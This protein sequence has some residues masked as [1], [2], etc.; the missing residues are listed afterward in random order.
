MIENS[1]GRVVEFGAYRASGVTENAA[2]ES[3]GDAVCSRA[4][5]LL[6]QLRASD[7]AAWSSVVQQHRQRLQALGRSYRLAPS[8][9]DDALQATW[10]SLL[11]HADELRNPDCL[12]A[13]LASTMRRACL[14]TLRNRGSREQLVDDWTSYE[15][16]SAHGDEMES[17]LELL[18][19]R[20]LVA[21]VW[22]LVDQLPPRQRVLIHSLYGA[23]EP[24]YADVATRTGVPVGAIGP[25]RQRALGRLR[26]ML[27]GAE[28]A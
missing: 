12:G 21:A 9:V 3:A 11:R 13:W 15:A 17:L 5:R 2:T 6:E 10:L 8:E 18:D 1:D 27:G 23:D 22:N 7:E 24:S 26:Q 20:E 14:A 4:G 19:R 16:A 28:A 25:T